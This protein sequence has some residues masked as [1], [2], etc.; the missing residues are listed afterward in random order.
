MSD[1][2]L[3]EEPLSLRKTPHFATMMG[4][5]PYTSELPAGLVIDMLTYAYSI[6]VFNETPNIPICQ[7]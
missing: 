3:D 1:K 2:L 7:Y 5:R 4:I 6:D